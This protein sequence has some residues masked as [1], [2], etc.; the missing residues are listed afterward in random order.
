MLYHIL[1]GHL[2]LWWFEYAWPR[3]CSIVEVGVALWEEVFIVA[4]GT[5][6]LLLTR[7]EPVFSYQP[8]DEDV[9]PSPP[10]VPCLFGHFNAPALIIMY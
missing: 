3:E 9:K 6:T 1:L 10:L 2:Y 4:L 7:W 5:E 8:S